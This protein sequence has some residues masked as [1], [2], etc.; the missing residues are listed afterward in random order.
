MVKTL[1]LPRWPSHPPSGPL[2]L[3]PDGDPAAMAARAVTLKKGLTCILCSSKKFTA[4]YVSRSDPIASA[5]GGDSRERLPSAQ[6]GRGYSAQGVLRCNNNVREM[7]IDSP[8]CKPAA[9]TVRTASRTARRW[10]PPTDRLVPLLLRRRPLGV[11]AP[12]REDARLPTGLSHPD[13]RNGPDPQTSRRLPPDRRHPR[14]DPPNP[15]SV[16]QP[17]PHHRRA[18]PSPSRRCCRGSSA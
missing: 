18:R 5:P 15:S 2:P 16:Q 17:A 9:M 8:L 7:R 6:I 3:I 1:A 10:R 4:P 14:S 12:S 11:V 13:H